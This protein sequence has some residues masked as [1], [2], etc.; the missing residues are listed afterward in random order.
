MHRHAKNGGGRRGAEEKRAV[1]LEMRQ[2]ADP[3]IAH[4]QQDRDERSEIAGRGQDRSQCT[5]RAAAFS[6]RHTVEPG[7]PE[8][9]IHYHCDFR[10]RRYLK[11]VLDYGVNMPE[12]YT[13]GALAREIGVNVETVRYY[14]RRGLLAEPHRPPRRIRRYSESHARRLRFIRRAQGLGFGLEEVKELL[15][16]GDGEHCREAEWHGAIKL[17]AVRERLAQLRRVE[18]A[19]AALVDQCHGNAEKV[20]CPLIAAPGTD[21]MKGVSS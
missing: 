4:A 8:H 11:T 16:L 3:G 10:G 1:G 18:R 9:S 21:R 6:G 2:V 5:K 20:C 15:A 13:I 7:L 14:Q 19:F 12:P 17:A